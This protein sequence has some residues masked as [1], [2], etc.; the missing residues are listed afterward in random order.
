MKKIPVENEPLVRDSRTGALLSTDIDAV[1]AYERK[2]QESK[3]QK[4][5]INKL[6]TEI[7]ELKEVMAKILETQKR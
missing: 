7:K 1:K 3:A 5:R 2:K 6:E 4:E